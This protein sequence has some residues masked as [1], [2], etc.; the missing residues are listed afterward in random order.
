MRVEDLTEEDLILLGRCID[1]KEQDT[2]WLVDPPLDQYDSLY[3]LIEAALD[4]PFKDIPM[5]IS[6]V[7]RI[8][9]A[10]YKFRLEKGV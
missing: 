9:Q 6:K 2:R 3:E 1:P 8:F 4:F 5:V 7:P 10:V